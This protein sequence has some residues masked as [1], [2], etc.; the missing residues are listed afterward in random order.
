MSMIHIGS[1][2]TISSLSGI[3]EGDIQPNAIDLRIDKVWLISK[4]TFILDDDDEGYKKHRGSLPILPSSTGFFELEPG[5]YEIVM[6]NKI[7]VGE[8]E[9][10]WVITRSTLNRNGIYITSGLYDSG[11]SGVM[12]GVLHV[13]C[14]PA[15]IKH[16]SRVGQFLLFKSECLHLYDGSYGDGKQHDKKYS[17]E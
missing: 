4:S 3:Q 1:N 11:Y 13:T 14:G 6:K 10:G 16:N 7:S 17:G 5:V 8:G 9:A 12:A 15:L 2:D